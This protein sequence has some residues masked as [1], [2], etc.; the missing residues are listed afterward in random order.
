MFFIGDQLCSHG[1]AIADLMTVACLAMSSKLS[2]EME[3]EHCLNT[4]YQQRFVTIAVLVPLAGRALQCFRRFVDLRIVQGFGGQQTRNHAFNCLKYCLGIAVAAVHWHLHDGDSANGSPFW[5]VLAFVSVA[6]SFWWDV[7]RDWGLACNPCDMKHG[8]LRED[9]LFLPHWSRRGGLYYA[10]VALNCVARFSGLIA[11]AL[12]PSAW[13]DGTMLA[14]G[15]IEVQI[16]LRTESMSLN[17]LQV[18]RRSVWNCFRMEW[19]QVRCR[20]WHVA[21]AHALHSCTVAG[22]NGGLYKT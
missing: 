6:Y 3:R 13:K 14:L 1:R 20:T 5:Y 2:V 9:L 10:A 7:T 21:F 8:G 16:S 12:V 15:L 4:N 22:G 18:C 19:E 11:I 17:N